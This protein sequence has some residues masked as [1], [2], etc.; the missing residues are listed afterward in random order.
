VEHNPRARA[1]P[2]LDVAAPASRSSA[3]VP[4]TPDFS[5][6]AGGYRRAVLGGSIAAPSPGSTLST[7]FSPQRRLFGSARLKFRRHVADD[8]RHAL[9]GG[10]IR[11]E[12]A[13]W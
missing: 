2:D 5:A 6:A 1:F 11:A 3:L 7:R 9:A 4:L 8:A 13:I 10:G 12:G